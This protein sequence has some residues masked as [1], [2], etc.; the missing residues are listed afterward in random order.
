M[1]LI[2]KGA[3][4]KKI[5]SVDSKWDDVETDNAFYDVMYLYKDEIKRLAKKPGAFDEAEEKNNRLNISGMEFAKAMGRATEGRTGVEAVHQNM[6]ILFSQVTGTPGE[7]RDKMLAGMSEEE[8]KFWG[9]EVL[10]DGD[11]NP[12][13][14]EDGCAHRAT[15]DPQPAEEETGADDDGDADLESS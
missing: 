6:M 8:K 1:L 12:P 3:G 7:T 15:W 10:C 2:G 13:E 14:G 5:G 11:G 9:V 4:S